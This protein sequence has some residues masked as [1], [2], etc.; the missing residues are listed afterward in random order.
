MKSTIIEP[1]YV[2]TV[3]T[4]CVHMYNLSST[5]RQFLFHKS[6]NKPARLPTTCMYLYG[7]EKECTSK[8]HVFAFS[9]ISRR[10]CA[11]AHVLSTLF[12]TSFEMTAMHKGTHSNTESLDCSRY[13]KI[14]HQKKHQKKPP[15]RFNRDHMKSVKAG[16]M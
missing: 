9:Q 2:T 4:C 1:G 5:G 6:G 12:H 11:H 7:L 16:H 13:L 14:S 8:L 15:Y 3:T 10:T